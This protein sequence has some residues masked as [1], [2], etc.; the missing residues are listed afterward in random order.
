M[1]S[2]RLFAGM[3]RPYSDEVFSSWLNRGIKR[4]VPK[5]TETAAI[6]AY[7]GITDPD[8]TKHTQVCI[9]S[10]QILGCTP[11]AIQ[12]LLPT[13]A[14]WLPPI[15]QRRKY[16]IS[17]VAEDLAQGHHPAY[18]RSW[19]HRWSV[20]C[21]VH[22]HP[23]SMIHQFTEDTNETLSHAIYV[24][25]SGSS[26]WYKFSHQDILTASLRRPELGYFLTALR[27]Q[28]WLAKTL[29]H[30][31]IYLPSGKSIEANHFLQII[32][33]ASI[34]LTKGICD[35]DL[36]LVSVIPHDASNETGHRNDAGLSPSDIV[37]FDPLYSSS[38]LATFGAFLGIP[39]CLLMW[40]M[41]S[42]NYRYNRSSLISFF[43]DIEVNIAD[44]I[45]KKLNAYENPH[46]DLV[47]AWLNSVREYRLRPAPFCFIR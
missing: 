15:T 35:T 1:S 23:L 39:S 43:P 16:C 3:H 26:P 9:L 47:E 13:P 11:S 36:A 4:G 10:A 22:L 21:P 46:I 27:F 38:L 40:H 14:L 34:T 42:R 41:L 5:F 30:S 24:A 8:S 12:G 20:G 18:R 29:K 7:Q 33:A 45:I 31:T 6:L 37:R 19:L 17:C 28:L 32:D 25:L 2:N 44:E